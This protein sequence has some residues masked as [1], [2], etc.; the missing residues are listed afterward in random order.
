MSEKA[1]EVASRTF[2][3]RIG[4]IAPYFRSSRRG[5]VLAF[6]GSVIGALTEP[7]IPSFMQHLLDAGFQQRSMPLWQIPVIVIGLFGLRGFAGFIA[8]Y[9]LAWAANRGMV[10]L[11]SALFA[12]LMNAEPA[13]FARNAASSLINTVTY[14]VQAGAGQLMHA[15]TGLVRDSLTLVALLGYLMWLNW[16]LTLFVG[17]LFPAVAW[18]MR[19]LSKR[20]HRLTVEGQR[21]TDE[22]AYVVEENV[23]AW[24][25]VRLH[26]AQASEASRF[27]RVSE[28]LRRLSVKA[29]VA[30]ATMTPLTQMLAACA[31]SAVIVVALWQ[32]GQSGGSVG[33]FV[34]FVM[35]MLQLVAPIKHLSEV[36]G[37][38]TRGVAALERGIHLVDTTPAEVG[39]VH[40]PARCEGRLELRDVTLQYSGAAAP[41]LDRVSI[42]LAPGETVALVGPS[43]AGKSTIVNLLPRFLEPSSGTLLLDGTP[44]H[45]WDIDALRRQFALVSQ[46]VVLFNDSI[47]ANVALGGEVDRQRVDAAL[48]GANLFD[49][50]QTLPQGIDSTIGH[51]GSQL[52]G[53][54]RQRLAIARAIYKDAPVLILDEATSALDSESERLVQDALERL[55][56]GRTSIVIAHRLSTI[57]RADR[58]VA[59]EGGRVVEQGTHAQ[60]LAAGGLYARLHALQFR[61]PA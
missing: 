44:L 48:R 61:S 40:A 7:M 49:F 46:D 21:A 35:A 27:A 24:R 19:T 5:I 54:Q 59:L 13:L 16:R 31:L 47:A 6:V 20:L 58:I 30:A 43:G 14:E 32:S 10:E 8:Q 39:G 37:P 2:W 41:A 55:M 23:L 25:I 26:S 28:T 15:M 50:V 12:R 45:D 22:L 18:I 1:A 33:G 9:G 52:S 34:A 60:L 3:Q 29:A 56:R 38:I 11:R 17:V 57:E 36:A 42:T 53:G 51:N 4:A